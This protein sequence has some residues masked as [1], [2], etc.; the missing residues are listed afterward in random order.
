MILP[1]RVLGRAGA[2]WITSGV[3]VGPIS[4]RTCWISSLR[5]SSV[6]V[7]PTLRVT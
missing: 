3:A 2:H 7:T 4:L 1:E 5:N 6:G